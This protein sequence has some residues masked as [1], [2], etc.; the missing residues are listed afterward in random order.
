MSVNKLQSGLIGSLCTAVVVGALKYSPKI[1]A[2]GIITGALYY[3]YVKQQKE[4]QSV[5]VISLNI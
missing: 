3:R 4:N 1:T 5:W 2:I